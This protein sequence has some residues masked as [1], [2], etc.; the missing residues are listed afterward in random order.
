MDHSKFGA[1]K[2]T[3]KGQ[4]VEHFSRALCDRAEWVFRDMDWQSGFFMQK[5][6]ETAEEGASSGEDETSVHEVGR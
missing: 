2:F 5:L 4:L 6:V 3:K 1:R